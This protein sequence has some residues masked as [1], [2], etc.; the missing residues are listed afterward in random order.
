[1]PAVERANERNVIDGDLVEAGKNKNKSFSFSF[2][3]EILEISH[4]RNIF[5]I[6]SVFEK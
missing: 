4:Q 3:K 1:M 6:S 2:A 5:K